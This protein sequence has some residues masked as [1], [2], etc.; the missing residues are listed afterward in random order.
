[1]P[2]DVPPKEVQLPRVRLFCSNVVPASPRQ[3]GAFVVPSFTAKFTETREPGLND[4]V[5][6]LAPLPKTLNSDCRQ[7]LLMFTV[8]ALWLTL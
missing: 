2:G 8:E 3:A 6:V 5:W 7:I 4:T 1:M